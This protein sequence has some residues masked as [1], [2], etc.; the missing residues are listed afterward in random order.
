MSTVG[1]AVVKVSTLTDILIID[2]KW[3]FA[4]M[5]L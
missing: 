2:H 4:H 1:R 3:T 5:T